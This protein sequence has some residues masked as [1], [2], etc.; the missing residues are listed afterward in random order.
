MLPDLTPIFATI[1]R[2]ATYTPSVGDAIPCRA[3]VQGGGQV[4]QI[5]RVRF[6]A[7]GSTFH[8]LRDAIGTP[9]DGSIIV[10]GVS[11]TVTA[12]EPVEGD[13]HKLVWGVTA[14]WGTLF[15][16]TTP[17]SG[18]GSEYDPPEPTLTYTAQAASAGA[19]TLTV[20]ASGWTTGRVRS[21]DTITVDGSDYEAT[22][23]VQLSLIGMNYG[24][25]NVP[26]TPALTGA[27]DGDETVTFTAA[28]AS[29]TRAVRAA[30]ADYE[31]TEI[32][33]GIAAGDRR[34]IVRAADIDGEPT[35][36]DSVLIDGTD[37]AVVSVETIH[38]GADV[39]A[40]VCQVRS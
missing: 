17:G 36:S 34:L 16:W 10:D 33:G 20:L 39:V 18:G 22:A 9:T 31:A 6:S 4:F 12:G 28:G 15:D 13:G 37:W 27:L 26:I 2:P 1:G 30:L 25:A 24:F 11:Y 8:V 5:G 38:Q 32:A 21:G 7:E 3:I 23:D 19:T 40:Y 35:T 29:N 14:D